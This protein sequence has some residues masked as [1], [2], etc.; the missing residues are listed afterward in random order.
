MC[1]ALKFKVDYNVTTP[2]S[3]TVCRA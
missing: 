1:T 2:I 3:G